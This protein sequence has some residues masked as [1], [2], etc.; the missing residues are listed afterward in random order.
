LQVVL[1]C[2]WFGVV[3]VGCMCWYPTILLVSLSSLLSI[4]FPCQQQPPPPPLQILFLL[5]CIVQQVLSLSWICSIILPFLLLIYLIFCFNYTLS[6]TH[7]P[8]KPP[9]QWSQLSPHT[10]SHAE[11]SNKTT[12]SY[13]SHTHSNATNKHTAYRPVEISCCHSPVKDTDIPA[14]ESC[15]IH[16]AS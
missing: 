5:V 16:C 10:V 6:L 7:T 13:N 4:P 12:Y 9:H 2:C 8:S 1:S 3:V 14:S 15:R 11:D